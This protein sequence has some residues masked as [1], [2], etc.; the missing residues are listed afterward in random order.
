MFKGL[1]ATT[2]IP[3]I[4]DFTQNPFREIFDVLT[5]S[6]GAWGYGL[7][8][9]MIGAII[10]SYTR[11]AVA[12]AGYLILLGMVGAVIFPYNIGQF[13][14]LIGAFAAT[15]IVFRLAAPKWR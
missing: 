15:V 12:V 7:F 10:Y 3:N 4:T 11:N 2:S 5:G 1:F 6:I 13:L 14:G 8:F 9:G